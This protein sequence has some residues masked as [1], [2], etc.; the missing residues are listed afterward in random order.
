MNM[1]PYLI[2]NRYAKRK[3]CPTGKIKHFTCNAVN[4]SVLEQ[5]NSTQGQRNRKLNRETT[6]RTIVSNYLK[7]FR[8]SYKLYRKVTEITCEMEIL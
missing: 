1:F 7:Y 3:A 6:Y 5:S 8:K 2:L 4:N